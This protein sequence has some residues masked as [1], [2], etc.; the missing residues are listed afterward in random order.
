MPPQPRLRPGLFFPC[1][2]PGP[3][4][5]LVPN[6]VGCASTPQAVVASASL[7][8]AVGSDLLEL[9]RDLLRDAAFLHRDAVDHVAR[10]H[11]ALVVGDHDEVAAVQ[12][13]LEHVAEPLDVGLV[14]CGIDLVEN[15][16]RRRSRC[17]IPASRCCPRHRAAGSGR[18]SR[19]RRACGTCRRGV[20]IQR[21]AL[22]GLR[23]RDPGGI[24][25]AE[26]KLQVRKRLL[27]QR[28]LFDLDLAS[29][30]L[31]GIG[32]CA[33]CDPSPSVLARIPR[34]LLD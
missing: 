5:V 25:L 12:E 17:R 8:R 14:E 28:F 34:L 24:P 1:P 4:P 20:A 21:L 29:G 19:H 7:Q 15:A 3:L 30:D 6:G 32:D 23:R 31:G 11:R 22:R 16:E 2:R 26:V 9:H 18:R 13:R 10:L 27:L 33:S